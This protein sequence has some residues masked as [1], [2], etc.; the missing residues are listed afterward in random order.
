MTHLTEN[1]QHPDDHVPFVS[2]DTTSLGQ[3]RSGIHA[4]GCLPHAELTELASSVASNGGQDTSQVF[5]TQK[6]EFYRKYLQS[7]CR[8]SGE[9]NLTRIREDA[10]SIPGFTH[11]VKDPA[12]P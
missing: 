10:G 2:K 5:L 7:A 9:R 11:W 6:N 3:I 8:G 1:P 12:L 4:Q